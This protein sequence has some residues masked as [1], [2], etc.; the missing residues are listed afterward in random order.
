M[1]WSALYALGVFGFGGFLF[2]IGRDDHPWPVLVLIALGWP[3]LL[4]CLIF[5]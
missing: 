5:I 3:L 2:A 4:L 1:I